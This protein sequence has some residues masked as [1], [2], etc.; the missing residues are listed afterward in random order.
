MRSKDENNTFDMISTMAN[1]RS[2][3][4]VASFILRCQGAPYGIPTFDAKKKLQQQ[5]TGSREPRNHR[6]LTSSYCRRCHS[7]QAEPTDHGHQDSTLLFL[8]N[9][10]S[11]AAAATTTTTTTTII[12]I[13]G[14]TFSSN[15]VLSVMPLHPQNSS[16][17]SVRAYPNPRCPPNAVETT[18]GTSLCICIDLPSPRPTVVASQNDASSP[19]RPRE[20]NTFPIHIVPKESPRIQN[21]YPTHLIPKDTKRVPNSN[22]PRGYKTHVQVASSLRRGTHPTEHRNTHKESLP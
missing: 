14:D 16:S 19:H 17:N 1:F 13:C 12:F 7:T 5:R 21:S 15:F 9:V 4:S 3:D 20:S 2:Y 8:E 22:R 6:R 10:N 11:A 18:S